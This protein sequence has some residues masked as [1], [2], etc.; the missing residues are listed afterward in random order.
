M[1]LTDAE[2][3]IALRFLEEYRRA[4]LTVVKQGHSYS[5][6]EFDQERV[7]AI[8]EILALLREFL[9]G[10]V[11]LT[12]LKES[13]GLLCRRHDYWGFKGPGGQMVL[14]QLTNWSNASPDMTSLLRSSLATPLD[15]NE[16]THK[17]DSLNDKL[18]A[19]IPE[20]KVLRRGSLPYFVSY[21][22]Q[23]QAPERIPV[24]FSSIRHTLAEIG[25][26]GTDCS[27]G[28]Y[29]TKFW[30]VQDAFADLYAAHLDMTGVNRYWL[31]EHVLWFHSHGLPKPPTNG[32]KVITSVPVT[33]YMQYIPPILQHFIK[34]SAGEGDSLSFEHQVIQL[35][36][37]LGFRV[38]GLGQGKGREPDG[39]AYCREYNYAILFDAKSSKTGFAIG[40]DDR[41]IVEYIRRYERELRREGYANIY[42]IIVSSAFKGTP[43]DSID[44]VRAHT[45]VKSLVLMTAEQ[46]LR[47]LASKIEHPAG[48]DFE[49][50]QS[51]LLDSG[52]LAEES[53]AE[54][55]EE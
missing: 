27:P 23:I 31:V 30:D 4:G 35:F 42:Y 1:N 26:L 9:A 43:K 13:H 51:L 33:H 45:P 47:L 55:L 14:N 46:A 21:F 39:I 24:Q 19:L 7:G 41:T 17:I 28:L 40:T 18:P 25:V 36:R 50:F 49:A 54:F 20:G 11:D 10:R 16:A 32:G 8:P 15:R 12:G 38:E 53:L 52:E 48:F 34:C 3:S 6:K 5:F 22:W 44:R 29:F 37:M 2:R